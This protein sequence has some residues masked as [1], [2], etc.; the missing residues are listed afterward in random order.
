MYNLRKIL[1]S[2]AESMDQS[3]AKRLAE[4]GA[5]ASTRHVEKLKEEKRALEEEIQDLMDFS[6]VT[7]I[8]SGRK[9][10]SSEGVAKAVEKYHALSLRLALKTQEISVAERIH[11]ELT[12]ETAG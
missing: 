10:M 11:K 12:D 1:G 5:A 6:A 2:S 4:S 9:A 3:R 7:D 8:N